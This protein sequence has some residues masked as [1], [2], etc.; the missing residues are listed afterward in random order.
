MP[1]D[2][3]ELRAG[4]A[5][6]QDGKRVATPKADN[7]AVR[8]VAGGPFVKAN[9]QDVIKDLREQFPACRFLWLAKPFDK[10]SKKESD[11]DAASDA[12]KNQ[13]PPIPEL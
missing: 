4:L 9:G 5:F 8:P 6:I 2:A 1:I 7:Y 13:N 3:K 11:K 12:D 10:E